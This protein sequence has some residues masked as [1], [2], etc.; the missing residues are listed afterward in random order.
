[1]QRP[2]GP[3]A[4]GRVAMPV[5][6]ARRGATDRAAVLA[7]GPT[8]RPRSRPPRRPNDS[9]ACHDPCR[10]PTSPD[11]GPIGQGGGRP[12]PPP[13]GALPAPSPGADQHPR[14]PGPPP[15]EPP[16]DTRALPGPHLRSRQPTPAPS[17]APTCGAAN[18]HPRPPGPPPRSRLSQMPA[19]VARGPIPTIHDGPGGA[20][21]GPKPLISA[22]DD[23]P[24]RHLT[25]MKRAPWRQSGFS[26]EPKPARRPT[27]VVRRIG[28]VAPEARCPRPR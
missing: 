8:A 11:A 13:R 6:D 7:R 17:R 18:R 9:C 20:G 28:P 16:T 26:T 27:Y 24:G 4:G 21:Q 10:G 25:A 15:A 3:T 14:P 1:M 23:N 19:P 12:T 5:G 2:F 22:P